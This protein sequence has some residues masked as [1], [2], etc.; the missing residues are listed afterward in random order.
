VI[1]QKGCTEWNCM[2]PCG[3]CA[4]KESLFVIDLPHSD[5]VFVMVRWRATKHCL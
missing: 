4:W 3:Q 2:Q 5:D 1:S